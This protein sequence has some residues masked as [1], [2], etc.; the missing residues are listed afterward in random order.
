MRFTKLTKSL[1]SIGWSM[2]ALFSRLNESSVMNLG[3]NNSPD[4][5]EHGRKAY[6]AWDPE[7]ESFDQI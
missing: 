1:R 5:G 4:K 6:Q 2:E 7:L 3:C